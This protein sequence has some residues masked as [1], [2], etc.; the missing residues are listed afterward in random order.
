MP[1]HGGS[2][3][4]SR[5]CRG[6]PCLLPLRDGTGK[7]EIR[8]SVCAELEGMKLIGKEGWLGASSMSGSHPQPGMFP[9]PHLSQSN[10]Q[11]WVKPQMHQKG[12]AELPR[13]AGHVQAGDTLEAGGA[14]G[15]KDSSGILCFSPAR[16]EASES[17]SESER[18][19]W[20]SWNNGG[21]L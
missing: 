17:A 10:S 5:G 21:Y 3:L 7:W 11:F 16:A 15:R 20:Q 1:T 12:D 6:A 14:Q 9:Q 8:V 2:S 13:A 4:S 18:A 19:R